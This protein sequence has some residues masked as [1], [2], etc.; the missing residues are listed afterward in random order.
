LTSGGFTS[1]HFENAVCA[2]KINAERSRA[3]KARSRRHSA[4]REPDKIS[5]VPNKVTTNQ[6]DLALAYSPGDVFDIE[7]DE[8]EPVSRPDPRP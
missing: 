6:W 3:R 4:G 5:V 2:N 8:R 1:G 7:L